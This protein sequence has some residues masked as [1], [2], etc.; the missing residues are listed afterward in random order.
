MATRDGWEM[1]E[2]TGE[3]H[4]LSPR[5]HFSRVSARGMPDQWILMEIPRQ[6]P[7]RLVELSLEE[8]KQLLAVLLA[9]ADLVNRA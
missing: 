2:G 3:S 9:S 5:L 4:Q 6:G 7:V 1:S 8:R